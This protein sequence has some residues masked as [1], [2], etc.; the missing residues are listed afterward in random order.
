MSHHMTRI[1]PVMKFN[2]LT[3]VE[4]VGY[5]GRMK[6]WKCKCDCG[7]E[8]VVRTS[9]LTSGHIESCDCL[10]RTRISEVLT[11]HNHARKGQISPT[12]KTWQ[13]MKQRCF[14]KNSKSYKN[15]G[16][17]GIGICKRWLV[18]ANFLKD[19]GE[20][21]EDMTIHRINNDGR[22]GPENCV[23]AT[24]AQQIRDQHMRWSINKQLIAA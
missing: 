2:M 20:R 4:H 22:Y 6:L 7:K 17:R 21:P 3:V 14:N 16:G 23:W 18:F 11:K 8:S 9:N 10:T 5:Q 15:Y 12:Y 1:E 24:R 13:A 19:M